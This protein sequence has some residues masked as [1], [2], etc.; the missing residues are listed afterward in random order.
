VFEDQAALMGTANTLPNTRWDIDSRTRA[1]LNDGELELHLA[2]SAPMNPEASG[3]YSSSRPTSVAITVGFVV[4]AGLVVLSVPT[5]SE[6]KV[7]TPSGTAVM[8][9]EPSVSAERQVVLK[10]E[11]EAAKTSTW[12]YG[13]SREEVRRI[14]GNPHRTVSAGPYELWFYRRPASHGFPIESQVRFD[15]S[16]RVEGW[17]DISRTL[18]CSGNGIPRPHWV[19]Y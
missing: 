8:I 2:R 15:S 10:P 13:A 4:A 18:H 19:R 12:T 1:V 11:A 5:E 7:A 16:G 3:E 14:E 6:S 9:S 17:V